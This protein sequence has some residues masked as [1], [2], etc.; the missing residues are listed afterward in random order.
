MNKL[1]FV[2]V[3]AGAI[4][5]LGVTLAV[6]HLWFSERPPAEF[7]S[8]VAAVLEHQSGVPDEPLARRV[9][10]LQDPC[11]R[12]HAF[13]RGLPLV[14]ARL[15]PDERIFKVRQACPLFLVFNPERK[16]P[17]P[18]ESLVMVELTEEGRNRYRWHWEVNSID[19]PGGG[20]CAPAEGR[21]ERR[22]GRWKALDLPFK[23]PSASQ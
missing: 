17:E 18:P 19:D 11:V 8:I 22:D 12:Q 6:R 9:S 23:G 10:V 4:V 15:G 3:L 7:C 1:V 20:A 2:M 5:L 14:D 21:V 13:W 16:L